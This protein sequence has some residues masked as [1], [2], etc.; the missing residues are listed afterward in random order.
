MA[1]HKKIIL[2]ATITGST[3]ST[4]QA[5]NPYSFIQNNHTAITGRYITAG[6]QPI[7]ARPMLLNTYH[8]VKPFKSFTALMAWDFK[9]KIELNHINIIFSYN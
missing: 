1:F 8:H 7:Q 4:L 6:M 2:L 9:L 5:R 3:F